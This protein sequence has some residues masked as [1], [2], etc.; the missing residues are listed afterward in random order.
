MAND[1]SGTARGRRANAA[2]VDPQIRRVSLQPQESFRADTSA[3]ELRYTVL[4]IESTKIVVRLDGRVGTL[5][6]QNNV[7]DVPLQPGTLTQLPRI[8][9][10]MPD[11]YI[12]VIERPTDN[13]VIIA[14]GP[15]TP[16][17][18]QG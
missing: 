13:E 8:V 12:A 18:A 7:F 5:T 4:S 14:T 17:K 1:R 2:P 9:K 3:Y 16:G 10:G 6:L 15:V 11:L